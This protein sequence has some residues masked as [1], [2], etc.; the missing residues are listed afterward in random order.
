[1]G[2][3]AQNEGVLQVPLSANGEVS[4]KTMQVQR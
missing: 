1:M 3:I 2:G 4:P